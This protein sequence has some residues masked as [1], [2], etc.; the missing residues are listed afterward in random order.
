MKR[1][2]F[3]Q[4]LGLMGGLALLSPSEWIM[5]RAW[6]SAAPLDRLS[7]L[8]YSSTN[9]EGAFTPGLIEGEIPRDLT[10]SLYRMT[11]G[12]KVNHGVELKHLFDGDAYVTSLRFEN[13]Q[14]LD[15]RSAFVQTDERKAEAAAGKMLY[16]EF[17]TTN[18]HAWSFKNSPNVNAVRFG[19]KLMALSEGGLP[20]AMD[21]ETLATEGYYNFS[22]LLPK[23]LTVSAHPK[24]DWSTDETYFYGITQEFYPRIKLYRTP[25]QGG[26]VQ[27]VGSAALN[28]FYMIHDMM[29]TKNYAVFVV[30]SIHVSLY[31][32]A[33]GWDCVSKVLNFEKNTPVR[34]LVMRKDGRGE[35][36]WFSSAPAACVFHHINAHESDDGRQITFDSVLM[37]DASV[38]DLVQAWADRHLPEASPSYITRFT[39]DLEH[40]AVS[41][42]RKISDGQPTDFPCIDPRLIGRRQRYAY[43][44]EAEI[45]T[46]DRLALNKLVRWDLKQLTAQRVHAGSDCVFGEPLFVPR[47]DHKGWILHLGYDRRCNQTFLDIRDDAT[48][49]LAARVW[50]NRFIPL[51]F[52]G[53]F[54]AGV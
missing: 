48:L 14:I 3:V 6:A 10:G 37:D 4:G 5:K 27:E 9:F 39:L 35:P 43:L 33:V 30:G 42:R 46:P 7:Y 23:Q 40:C 12:Q 1:R 18:P 34:I 25:G 32:A 16:H 21:P 50:M 22:G 26:S 49:D 24:H 20:V 36:K 17:G 8:A 15:A 28:D 51:G 45:G 29:L 52:H 54:F 41:E 2:D 11:P 38:L 47:A 31:K 53:T 19:G 13:G 44:L